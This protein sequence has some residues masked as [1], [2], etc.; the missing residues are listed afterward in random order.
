MQEEKEDEELD[1]ESSRHVLH[2]RISEVSSYHKPEEDERI[3]KKC[4][5]F[6]CE[7]QCQQEAANAQQLLSG[8]EEAVHDQG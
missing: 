2:S 1:K 7:G 3:C 8:E 5:F 6:G 4:G